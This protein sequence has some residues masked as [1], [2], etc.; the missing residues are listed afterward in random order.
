MN[1]FARGLLS[2]TISYTNNNLHLI[3]FGKNS[4]LV[5]MGLKLLLRKLQLAVETNNF[6]NFDWKQ[7]IHDLTSIIK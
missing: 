3:D 5:K 1:K 2:N 7:L 4:F 6:G